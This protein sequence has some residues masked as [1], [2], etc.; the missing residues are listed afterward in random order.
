MIAT[1]P[2][3][4]GNIQNPPCRSCMA[5]VGPRVPGVFQLGR[6]SRHLAL[7]PIHSD[8]PVSLVLST[9]AGFQLRPSSSA[10]ILAPYFETVNPNSAVFL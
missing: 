3:S 4:T 9:P 10:A 7:L 1:A 8:E 6:H 5:R 2:P